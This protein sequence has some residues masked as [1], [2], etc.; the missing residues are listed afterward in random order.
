MRLPESLPRYAASAHQADGAPLA[1]S[2]PIVSVV[3]PA[4]NAAHTIETQL[5]ALSSQDFDGSWELIVSDN[6]S[7][8]DLVD[9]VHAWKDRIPGL[10]IVDSS[11][12]PG[13]AAARN[14]GARAA[15]GRLLAFCDADDRVTRGWLS[16]M[17][18]ALET[19]SLVAGAIDHDT[20]N[21]GVESGSHHR[22]HRD[23][24][25]I[26]SR[27]LPYA[28]SSNMGV[29][30]GAFRQVGGFPEDLGTLGGAA[31]ED[32]A[33]SWRLQLAG[34]PLH[35][36]PGAIVAYRHRRGM[37]SVW[38]QHVAYGHAEVCLYRRFRDS[39]VPRSRILTALSVYLRL[40]A[41][42]GRL[43]SG[44]R[45]AAWIREAARRYG[46]LRGSL[47]NRIVYL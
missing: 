39:G 35:F 43:L 38:K 34:F 45:R 3:I 17:V 5:D 21:P 20:L 13:A 10:R 24:A 16:G 30:A 42:A 36:E 37:A 11:A 6:G 46:R 9:V 47:Q 25:P 2:D 28:L 44:R 4:L 14:T 41:R 26:G 18:S 7:T 1:A 40:M 12:T 15:R 19:H 33:L 23:S 29:R 8:D 27:F 31:G 32:I 22:S